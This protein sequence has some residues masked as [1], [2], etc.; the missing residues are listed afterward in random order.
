MTR[1]LLISG[2]SIQG[3]MSAFALA[4]AGAFSATMPTERIFGLSGTSH[5]SAGVHFLY[6]HQDLPRSLTRKSAVALATMFES[7]VSGGFRLTRVR[8]GPGEVS[9]PLDPAELDMGSLAPKFRG[10][11]PVLQH[12]WSSCCRSARPDRPTRTGPCRR[13][14]RD[15]RLALRQAARKVSYRAAASSIACSAVTTVQTY[16]IHRCVPAWTISPG[17]TTKP[18]NTP[19]RSALSAVVHMP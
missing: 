5:Y 8:A 13:D 14:P 10:Q 7:I 11:H 9:E 15:A 1:R 16:R 3:M 2:G 19:E 12:R 6:A 18:C 4:E 17:G